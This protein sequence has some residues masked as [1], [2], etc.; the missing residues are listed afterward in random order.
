MQNNSIE[1]LQQDFIA[2]PNIFSFTANRP[3]F[4]KIGT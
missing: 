2:T 4:A 1:M 3:T